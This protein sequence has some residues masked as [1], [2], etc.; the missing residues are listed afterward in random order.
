MFLL[1]W[2]SLVPFVIRWHDE[3]H[4]SVGATV[5]Y[6]VVLGMAA[7]GYQL[8]QRAIIAC[9]GPDSPV[10]RAIGADWKGLG[11]I[12]IYAIAVPLAFISRPLAI[13]LYIGVIALWLIPDRRMAVA[14]VREDAK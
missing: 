4:F 14:V 2:L 11:S 12:V 3:S 9:N 6:G 5:A 1:F 13:A 8:T 7:I 10:A